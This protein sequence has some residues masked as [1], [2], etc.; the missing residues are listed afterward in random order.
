LY[1]DTA[2]TIQAAGGDPVGGWKDERTGTII[3]TQSDADKRPIA[4]VV[5]GKMVLVSD[6]VDDAMVT[7]VDLP[8]PFSLA[9]SGAVLS[10]SN[11]QRILQSR[12]ENRLITFNR[13][14]NAVFLGVAVV[15][16]TGTSPGSAPSVAVLTDA[17]TASCFI[18]GVDRTDNPAV[19]ANWGR[20]GIMGG[21]Q[22]PFEVP[23]GYISGLFWKTGGVWTPT[24]RAAI[25]AF[26]VTINP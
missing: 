26:A 14:S 3:A 24:E 2:C 6:G 17:A 11:S 4:T 8:N 13:F 5:G 12:D 9:V 20:I 25:E 21:G 10:S 16:D 7:E 18:N 22:N 15:G 19:S 1:Q 23:D